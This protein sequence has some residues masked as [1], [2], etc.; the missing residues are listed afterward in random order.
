MADAMRT[1]LT[2]YYPGSL[3]ALGNT[4]GFQRVSLQ[5]FGFY[6]HGKTSLINLCV[7]SV[8][9]KQYEDLAGLGYSD[10]TVI[11]ERREYQLTHNLFIYDNRGFNSMD[12]E[13]ISEAS[14]Q[15]RGLRLVDEEVKWDRTIEEKMELLLQKNNNP[16]MELMVPVLV[17]RGAKELTA[18]QSEKMKVFVLRCF[19]ITGMFPLVVLMESG[20]IQEKISKSFHLLGVRYVIALQKF[21]VQEPELDAET[22]SEIL[23]FLNLC[24]NEAD[25]G[26]KKLQRVGKEEECRRHIR[27][28]M[29]V[30]LELEREK[31]RKRT[32]VEIQS[33][34]Q[35]S[36]PMSSG[37]YD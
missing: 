12:P 27:E 1:K 37:L 26:M 17:F 7:S 19:D 33:T 10:G 32:K 18:E 6:G 15:L 11:R 23:R 28:Q 2:Q 34:Q 5:L 9:T 36:L 3:L 29:M 16:L 20:E 35:V 31:V 22:E 24:T 8:Q 30:E 4:H 25:R 14:A 21:K 13:E